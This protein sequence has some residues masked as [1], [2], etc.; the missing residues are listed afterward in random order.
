MAIEL[1]IFSAIL[2]VSVILHLYLW[3]DSKKRYAD[4]MKRADALNKKL[5]ELEANDVE[6]D[7][8]LDEVDGD[9][10]RFGNEIDN[11][12]LGLFLKKIRTTLKN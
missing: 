11:L 9:V 10:E 5:R 3:L 1:I 4:Y 6:I 7:K 2:V 8:L 12:R